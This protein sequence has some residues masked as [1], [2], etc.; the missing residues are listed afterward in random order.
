MDT[1]EEC[2]SDL[3]EIL[4]RLGPS[5]Q[6][7]INRSELSAFTAHIGVP[8]SDRVRAARDFAEAHECGFLYDEKMEHGIFFRAD[9]AT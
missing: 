2:L 5:R 6:L 4:K 7:H 3:S 9:F 8:V 1:R